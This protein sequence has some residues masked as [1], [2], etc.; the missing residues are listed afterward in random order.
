[1][2]YFRLIVFLNSVT[3]AG[4]LRNCTALLL[5]LI[6][7]LNSTIVNASEP[8]KENQARGGLPTLSLAPGMFKFIG[9]IG[10]SKANEPLLGKSGF[11]IELQ[12]K[13]KAG[14]SVSGILLSGQL[15]GDERNRIGALNFRTTLVAE[16]LM[17][18]YEFINRKQSSQVLVPYLSAGI[19]YIFFKTYSDLFDANGIQYHYWSDGSIRNLAQTDTGSGSAIRLFRDHTF[20]TNIRDANPDGLGKYHQSSWAIPV[21]AGVRFVISPRVS[22]QLGSV[23]H[24]ANTDLLDG[25]SDKGS[26]QRKGDPSNDK[27]LFTSAAFRYDFSVAGSGH[28]GRRKKLRKADLSGVDFNALLTED[29]D[30][31][32]IPDVKD[33]SSATPSSIQVDA[34]GKP[35]DKDNDGIPD[36]RD[37][38]LNSAPDAVVTVDG[39]TI[40]EE[41]IEEKFIRDS[42]AAIPALVEYIQSYDRLTER[43]PLFEKAQLEKLNASKPQR[44]RVPELYR[45][46]DTDENEYIS[47]KEI[48]MAIDEYLSGKS[49]Y[50]I[51]EFYNLIDFFFLQ[52]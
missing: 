22:M 23:L 42:L 7:Y 17:F 36:Y 3:A 1:M 41:M 38:E 6:L 44:A 2:R 24:L 10:Y 46:L 47:P 27:F 31:D 49:A 16:G 35:I 29:A 4:G 40:T 8:G 28:G 18:R 50:S 9:D 26:G 37:L 21:G 32:G 39:V 43:N 19:E 45:R 30:K 12:F 5:T 34:S 52:K 11:Q 20:E 14:F 33:D 51:P 48:S 15:E 25:I 13:I